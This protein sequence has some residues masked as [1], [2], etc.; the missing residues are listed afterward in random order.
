M[1]QRSEMHEIVIL[2]NYQLPR[3]CTTS[4]MPQVEFNTAEQIQFPLS[5][6]HDR[7]A[8]SENTSL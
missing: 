8:E 7:Q 6:H 4:F 1:H 5:V 2:T 3:I